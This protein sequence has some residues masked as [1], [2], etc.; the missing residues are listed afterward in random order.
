MDQ[1]QF[2]KTLNEAGISLSETQLAQF[3]T[4]FKEL[5][6]ANQS[7]NLTA[8]TEKEEVY[9]KHF[10]D[11]LTLLLKVPELKNSRASLIDVGSGAGFPAL[12]LKIALPDLQVTMVDSLNKRVNF[13]K[14][15]VDKL[16]LSGVTVLHGR[17]EDLG[18]DPSLRESFDFATA[19]AVARTQV[20]A[21]YTLPFVKVGG[22]FL[23]MKGSAGQEEMAAGQKA[24]QLLGGKMVQE[25]TFTLPN[26]DP[27]VV[28]VVDKIGK[29]PKKYPRQAGTPTKKPL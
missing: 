26:G 9:L 14:E 10:F 15:M 25:M 19:R 2:E 13:L 29:T 18:K 16:G 7:F 5:V 21:E 17:A 8:I 22:Q 4:Y 20:L 1:S 12:P 23:V 3:D 24:L 11:S 6:L 27:R 28:Q